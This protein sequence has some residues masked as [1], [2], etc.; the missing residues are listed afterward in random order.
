MNPDMLENITLA[1]AYDIVLEDLRKAEN[2]ISLLKQR[3]STAEAERDKWKNSCDHFREMA[4]EIEAERDRLTDRIKELED[5]LAEE[6]KLSDALLS[7][8]RGLVEATMEW[9]SVDDCHAEGRSDCRL[10][11][12]IAAVERHFSNKNSKP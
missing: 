1:D 12:A 3:L 2:K 6:I 8:V 7:D 10:C 11:K 5:A 9:H 4:T